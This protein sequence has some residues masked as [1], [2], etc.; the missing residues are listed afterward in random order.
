[1]TLN[2]LNKNEN[3]V[4]NIRLNIVTIIVLILKK[5]FIINIL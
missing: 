1:M 4:I 3:I 5:S 2:K